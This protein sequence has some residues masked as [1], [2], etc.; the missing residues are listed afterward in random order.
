MREMHVKYYIYTVQELEK[1]NSFGESSV[2]LSLLLSS[3]KH[4]SLFLKR[5]VNFYT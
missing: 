3:R 4:L 2:N 1:Q 5:N